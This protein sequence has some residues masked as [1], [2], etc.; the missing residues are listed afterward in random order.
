MSRYFASSAMLATGWERD[1]LFDVNDGMITAIAPGSD[2][3]DAEVC[4]GP[5]VPGMPN[6]H[7]HAFQRAMAGL[8]QLGGPRGDDFW[9]WRE[10][11]YRFLQQLTPDDIETIATQLYIEMLRH[12]YTAV[13]EFHYVHHDPAGK[14]YANRAE[15]G[16]RILAAAQTAGIG[17]T[18]MPVLYA[19][20]AFGGAP[21]GAEQR[22]F[23]NDLDG[24]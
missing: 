18:L 6:V 11:M 17:L 2:R 19:H 16:E 15:T 7:S 21:P 12:G 10:S 8:T 4:A 5:V 14:P 9:S 1:V 23:I 20:G 13:A 22:R 3:R 24:F